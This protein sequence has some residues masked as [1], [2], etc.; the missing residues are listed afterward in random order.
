MFILPLFNNI[1]PQFF[2]NLKNEIPFKINFQHLPAIIENYFNNTN[3]P[4]N[5]Q[6]NQILPH[7]KPN[8]GN[9]NNCLLPTPQMIQPLFELETKVYQNQ[10]QPLFPKNNN[11]IPAINNTEQLLYNPLP[12]WASHLSFKK[13]PVTKQND[14][15][16]ENINCALNN[17]TNNQVRDNSWIT[18]TK[19][20]RNVNIPRIQAPKQPINNVRTP[21]RFDLLIN[22]DNVDLDN[23]GNNLIQLDPNQPTSTAFIK[24]IDNE[25]NILQGNIKEQ[26]QKRKATSPVTS[27]TT[28]LPDNNTHNQTIGSQ[29]KRKNVAHRARSLSIERPPILKTTRELINNLKTA[30]LFF[31]KNKYDFQ[32][33]FKPSENTH[34][35][36]IPD[37]HNAGNFKY[38]FHLIT[39]GILN[40]VI[41]KLCTIFIN[42]DTQ[43]NAATNLAIYANLNSALKYFIDTELVLEVDAIEIFIENPDFNKA[44]QEH[45]NKVIAICKKNNQPLYVT[46]PENQLEKGIQALNN[47]CEI[48]LSEEHFLNRETGSIELT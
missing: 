4:I 3:I 1:H 47:L 29:N 31:N 36:D 9:V 20:Q 42:N 38:S 6:Q 11:L 17:T 32:T 43:S 41:P 44:D 2:N 39:K 23:S 48:C 24:F 35:L 13:I 26:N 5:T 34:K 14:H 27:P 21:N 37:N 30:C 7:N 22:H 45:L 40:K 46:F 25:N 15:V 16:N 28:T 12:T 18:P 10:I 19:N 33:H 8:T